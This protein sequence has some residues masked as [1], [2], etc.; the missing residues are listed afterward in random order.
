VASGVGALVRF[1]ATEAKLETRPPVNAA[2]LNAYAA[3]LT[4][5]DGTKKES[6]LRAAVAADPNFVPAQLAAFSLFRAE[7]KRTEMLAAAKQIMALD[8]TNI[9][10]ARAVAQASLARGDLAGSFAGYDAVLQREQQD[11][12]ALNVIARYA[13]AA[14]DT[15]RFN[16]AVARLRSMPPELVTAHA[17]DLLVMTGRIGSAIDQYYELENA[18]PRNGSLALKIGRIAVL[19]RTPGLAE[20]ELRKL[21]QSDPAYGYHIL[22]A[23]IAAEARDHA[24]VEQE[25]KAAFA[26]SVPGDDYWTNVAEIYAIEG[27][28]ARRVTEALERAVARHEP[29]GPY[30]LSNRLFSYLASEPRFQKLTE[31]VKADQATLRQA[32]ENVRL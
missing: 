27:Q 23:Y 14:G 16:T 21:Q 13:A 5:T 4:T 25:L 12:D 9:E 30:I 29:T 18:S 32:L 15:R 10:A 6:F 24:Q 19:R 17:P 31:T 22:K 2:A 1:A 8:P 11:I 28:D 26:A 7:G 3:A 20:E